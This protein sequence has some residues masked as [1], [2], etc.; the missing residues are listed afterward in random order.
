MCVSVIYRAVGSA[1]QRQARRSHVV[2]MSHEAVHLLEAVC[3]PLLLRELVLLERYR[4]LFVVPVRVRVQLVQ[5][6]VRVEL[7]RVEA[8]LLRKH[9]VHVLI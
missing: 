5:R 9:R 7:F 1:S 2:I 4:Q 6:T 8:R 3:E